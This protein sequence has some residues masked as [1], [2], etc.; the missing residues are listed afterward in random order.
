MIPLDHVVA[1]SRETTLLQPPSHHDPAALSVN[2]LS[3]RIGDRTILDGVSLQVPVG[4][5]A[6]L[7]G[8]NGAG[9]TTLFSLITRL[10]TAQQGSIRI[11]ESDLQRE[12][13][14]ALSMLGVVFQQRALDPDLSARQN[15][16]YHAA[17]HGMPWGQARRRIA[18]ELARVGL[19]EK[20]D[21][22]IRA[23]SG[24]EA[25][26]VELARALLHDPRLLLCDEATVGL[27]IKSRGEIIV[28]VRGLVTARAMSVL[29]ATHLIDEVQPDDLTIILHRGRILRIGVAADIVRELGA[30]DIN[31]AFRQLTEG[32]QT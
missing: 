2:D 15:L 9:K 21:R 12:S 13:S 8:L 30:V 31:D 20:A 11:F 5:F 19:A 14:V 29:W 16:W 27:D 24:G 7:L 25:R 26:R 10:Y 23:F 18:E 28:D 32:A 3:H 17:L 1:D 6:V 22:K 4:R